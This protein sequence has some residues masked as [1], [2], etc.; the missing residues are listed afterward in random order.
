MY[1][2][3]DE[4]ITFAKMEFDIIVAL[5]RTWV[6]T[7]QQIG[8]NWPWPL[9]TEFTALK[10]WSLFQGIF[11]LLF[12][13]HFKANLGEY[14]GE[15]LRKYLGEYLGERARSACSVDTGV[16]WLTFLH[17]FLLKKCRYFNSKVTVWI[18]Y[19]QQLEWS[20]ILFNTTKV[21]GKYFCDNS[22]WPCLGT[23]V[24]P[25]SN[26]NIE[27]SISLWTLGSFCLRDNLWSEKGHIGSCFK[28]ASP[29]KL[30]F[31]VLLQNL[32]TF[33]ILA[34]IFSW[35]FWIYFDWGVKIYG[36][37]RSD[38]SCCSRCSFIMVRTR[39]NLKMKKGK[40]LNLWEQLLKWSELE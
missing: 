1:L 19:L 34:E 11:A 16:L 18:L 32:P 15:Y 21:E 31:Q 13:P 7:K 38:G 17:Q 27:V 36:R 25:I 2:I 30:L 14:L 35:E 37:Q 20:L 23:M 28:L 24:R 22:V 8:R 39:V 4:N 9:P 3:I 29:L 33:K 26:A 40:T 5:S 12:K 6:E 10:L